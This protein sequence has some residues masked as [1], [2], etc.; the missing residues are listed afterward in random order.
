M[1]STIS[2]DHN[3][4]PK[5]RYSGGAVYQDDNYDLPPR[6]NDLEYDVYPTPPKNTRGRGPERIVVDISTGKACYAS[7]HYGQ[8]KAAIRRSFL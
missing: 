7:N 5:P 6:G 4:S 2:K 3:Q 8:K 1:T